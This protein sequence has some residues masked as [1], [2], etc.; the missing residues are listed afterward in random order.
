MATY[1]TKITFNNPPSP[2]DIEHVQHVL[3]NDTKYRTY[4][5]EVVE[6]IEEGVEN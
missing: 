5:V 2:G 3:D 6:K 4:K 1:L